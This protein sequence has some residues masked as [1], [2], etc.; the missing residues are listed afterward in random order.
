MLIRIRR[1]RGAKTFTLRNVVHKTG[2]EMTFPLGG[3]QIKD[4]SIILRADRSK[5]KHDLEGN[6][7]YPRWPHNKAYGLD[8][9]QAAWTERTSV[10]L[11]VMRRQA[12][13]DR[14]VA[15][16]QKQLAARAGESPF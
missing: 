8:A 15:A 2:V 10:A 4:I 5:Y 11:E 1:G 14:E 12:Q 13:S 7:I 9:N 3:P 6:L 16:R